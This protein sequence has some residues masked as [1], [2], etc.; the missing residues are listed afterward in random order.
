[1][2]SVEKVFIMP[3]FRS[4]KNNAFVLMLSYLLVTPIS[5]LAGAHGKG[6]LQIVT[7]NYPPY[8]MVKPIQG[9]QGFD[10][11]LATLIFKQLRYE[12]QITF[13]PWKRAL[14]ETRLGNTVG[15][16]TCAYRQERESFIIYSDPISE[17]TNGFYTR[18]NH[19]GI[20]P[21][22]LEDVVDLKVA[23]I[24]EYESLKALQELGMT[25]IAAPNTKTA[26]RMLHK[27]RFDYL[28]V[29]KQATDFE[30]RLAGL[31]GEFDFHPILTNKF[32]FCFSKKFP[33]IRQIVEDFN[34]A[35]K[36]LQADGTIGQIRSNYQ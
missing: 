4:I 25:P 5:V 9:L 1:M 8:E 6:I 11:E 14:Q 15:I 2:V 28:Y 12:P 3:I 31:S 19:R 7:E 10:Y 29:A 13:Y 17:F 21:K 23:S 33:N 20:K 34:S 18:K 26:V 30:I 27:N 24:V 36:Q 16:L 32:Y 22:T 35:L